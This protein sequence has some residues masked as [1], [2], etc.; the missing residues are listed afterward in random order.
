M[1]LSGCGGGSTTDATTTT[2]TP[3]TPTISGVAASGAPLANASITITCSDGTTKTGTADANGAYSIDVTGCSGPYVVT[4]S[5][6]SGDAVQSLVS[7]L[8]TTV[9]GSVTVNVTPITNAIAATLASDGNPATLA[10]NIATEKANITATS[11]SD[12]NAALAAA[13]A[14]ALTQAGVTGTVDLISTSFSANGS[15][16]DKVLDN[17]K[18]TVTPGGVTITNT[19]GAAADDMGN[20]SGQT[21]ASDL[22]S[23]AITITSTTNF[24]AGLTQLPASVDDRTVADSAK[25]KLNACFAVPAAQRGTFGSSNLGT[26]CAALPVTSDYLNDG[27]TAAQDFDTMLQSAANDGAQFDKPEI[28][29]FYSN[30]STDARA[31]VRFSFKRSDG[32]GGVL[33]TVAEKSSNTGNAWKLRGN[34][35]L[36]RV[37]VNGYVTREEQLGT[38]GTGT[39]ARPKGVYFLSG[40]N[41]YFGYVEGAAGGAATTSGGPARG[42]GRKVAYVVVTGPGLPAAGVTLSPALSGCDSFYSITSSSSTAPSSCTSLFRMQYRKASTADVDNPNNQNSFGSS[43][44]FAATMA[45]DATITAIAPFSAYTFKIF[46]AGNST[47]TPDLVYVERLRSRP[48]ALGTTPGSGEVDKLTFNAGLSD[49]T[50][51]LVN[52]TSSAPFTGGSSF[53]MKW[54]NV[55]GAP[56][57]GSVQVQSRPTGGASGTLY[58]DDKNVGLAAS[59]A[60]LTNSGQGW[61]DMS[62]ATTSGNYNLAELRARDLNDT[63]YFHNWRY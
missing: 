3:A 24:K 62:K 14:P 44:D 56:P 51:A 33:T 25:D 19:G 38:R 57:I 46:N 47:A 2:T 29:R 11:V 22:S 60:T 8:P 40:V 1:A 43:P 16:V 18:V 35:R 54:T 12:R 30:T 27:K 28:V 6:Q 21:V 20:V 9:T 49:E 32:S 36:Y 61:G 59:S 26:A 23:S 7:V 58:Q 41:L 17:V 39:T 55:A 45:T 10:A 4:A 34:Q 42:T 52:P 53:T 15:G 37:F 31:L 48:V 50:K 63:Q 5:V 13:L